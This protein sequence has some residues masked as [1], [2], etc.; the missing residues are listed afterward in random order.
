M[1]LNVVAAAAPCCEN[2]HQMCPSRLKSTLSHYLDNFEAGRAFKA[3]VRA[4][5]AEKPSGA[6]AVPP[7]LANL[8]YIGVE[9]SYYCNLRCQ[10]CARLVEGHTEGLMPKDRFERLVPM[11]KFL[12]AVLLFGWGE[13]L[14]HP[15]LP[16]FAQ[17]V[18]N[19]GSRPHLITNGML[20]NEN[21]AR[22]LLDAGL[23]DIQISMD[24]AKKE[25]VESIRLGADFDRILANA[26]RFNR[27]RQSSSYDVQLGWVFVQMRDNFRE[28]PA[29]VRL[30]AD[31]GYDLFTAKLIERNAIDF[32]HDH[33]IHN[34]KGEL[35]IDSTEYADTVAAA[36]QIAA[37]TGIQLRVTPFFMGQNGS[38]VANTY[39]SCFVDWLG[40]V[41][42]CCL[43][44][45]RDQENHVHAFGNVDEQD[46]IEILLSEKSQRFYDG[47]RTRKLT[48]AC[49]NCYQLLRLPELETYS[50][51]CGLKDMEMRQQHATISSA[52]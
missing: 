47:W 43:I 3:R 9:I 35:V 37:E 39:V 5:N 28:L 29:A 25:T 38:C 4:A 44:P 52:T 45:V 50:F 16:E 15:Q 2:E 26:R 10:M 24:G 46:F 6:C 18:S 14:M 36:E 30:A 1:R 13:P 23:R 19:A 8:V 42:P 40:W 33:A 31:C 7:Q 34:D 49:T 51:E 11:F 12:H 48:R 32:E 20:L 21:R 41:L 17:I 27:L 22:A